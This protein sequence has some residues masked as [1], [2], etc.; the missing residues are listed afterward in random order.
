MNLRVLL[1]QKIAVD[2]EEVAKVRAEGEDGAFCLLPRHVDFVTAIVPGLFAFEDEQGNET[3]LAIDQGVLVK[4]GDDVLVSTTRVIGGQP[5]GELEQAVE[6][7]LETLDE[8]Q[9]RTRRALSRLEADFVS[10]LVE[11][12]QRSHA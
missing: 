3:L 5:L 8:Q 1:P 12:E 6:E 11:M 2:E 7:E 10:R 4:C 9:R